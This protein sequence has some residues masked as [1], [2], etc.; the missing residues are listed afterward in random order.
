MKIADFYY[1]EFWLARFLKNFRKISGN[2]AV[3]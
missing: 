3:A 2:L 1:I